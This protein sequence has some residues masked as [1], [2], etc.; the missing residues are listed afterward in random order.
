VE[1]KK[2]YTTAAI[3]NIASI[4]KTF[5]VVALLKA[6]ELGQLA[7]RRSHQQIPAFQTG[8]SALPCHAITL[9]QLATHTSSIADNEFYET[10]SYVLKPG[11][12]VSKIS[13]QFEDAQAFIPADSAVSMKDFFQNVLLKEGKWFHS[14]AFLDKK[15]G[16]TLNIR[17]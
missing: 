6:Q 17:I 14:S 10:K 15:P 8:K 3:Q 16:S 5:I 7:T 4:S 11:Q 13:L 1:A 9:R 2:K 12:D